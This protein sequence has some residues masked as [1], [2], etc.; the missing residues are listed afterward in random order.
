MAQTNDKMIGKIAHQETLKCEV[1]VVKVGW[2]LVNLA[3]D[4]PIPKIQYKISEITKAGIV[5]HIKFLIWAN[6]SEPA[7]AA[8]RLVE[9]E[10][11]EDKRLHIETVSGSINYRFV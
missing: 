7:I 10:S 11:G 6:K 2:I 4:S 1:K 3:P 9:S 8:A 5:V